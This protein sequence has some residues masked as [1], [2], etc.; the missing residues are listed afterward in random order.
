[1]V[2]LKKEA[3]VWREK[4][5][6]VEAEFKAFKSSAKVWLKRQYEVEAQTFKEEC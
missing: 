4:C 5:N 3:R 1:M 2:R 6:A